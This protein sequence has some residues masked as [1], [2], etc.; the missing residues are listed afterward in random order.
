MVMM[1]MTMLPCTKFPLFSP[2]S[3]L[4]RFYIFAIRKT[5]FLFMKML[6]VVG[7][8]SIDVVDQ[9]HEVT[10][11]IERTQKICLTETLKYYWPLLGSWKGEDPHSRTDCDRVK[12][13]LPAGK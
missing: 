6:F 9:Q 12:R 7:Q 2:R 10:V 5:P 4:L 3:N 1:M 11:Q 8:V 13:V